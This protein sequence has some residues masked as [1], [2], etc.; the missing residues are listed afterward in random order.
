MAG[1]NVLT[2]L[3]LHRKG[4]NCAQSVALPFCDGL[5]VDKE[6]VLKGLEGFGAGMGDMNHTCGALSGA[7]FVAGLA[8]SGSSCEKGAVGKKDT[9][10]LCR[11]ITDSFVKECGSDNCR[12]LKGVDTGK[13]LKSCDECVAA[14][15]KITEKIVASKK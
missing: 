5:G 14:A 10:A 6:T 11:E 4:F 15:A 8:Q 1:K 13:P 7:V 2:A 9:Y 12:V 3:S